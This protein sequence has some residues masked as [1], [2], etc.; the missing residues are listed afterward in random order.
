MTPRGEAV[1]FLIGLLAAAF[2]TTAHADTWPSKSLRAIVAFPAGG[3]VDFVARTV[4]QRLGEILQ[5]PIIVEN[6]TGAS[7][8]I[9]ADAVA[10]A[11]P[12]GYTFLIASPAEVLVGPISGQK[13]PYDP[14]K[15][16]VA[17]T[18]VGETP[19]VI[20]AHPGVA[21]KTIA[22]LIAL[23]KKSPGT[24]SYGTPGAGSSMHF[25]GE[26]LNAIAGIDIQHIPYRGAAPAVTD[27]LGGQVPLGIVGMPPTVPHAKSG[28]LRV[29]AVTSDKRSSAMPEVPTVA[30]T[31]GFAGYRFTN[32]MG[33]Y[34]PAK[35][36]PAIVERIAAEIHNIVREPDIR[37]KLL[38]GGVEPIG[39]TPDEFRAF[40]DS[41][42]RTYA[43]VA[44]D[45]GIRGDD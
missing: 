15:D 23:A 14:Q 16:L 30:E 10:K 27:L 29:L 2:V 22:D 25:A 11:E 32:W 36:P 42:R 24:F 41:E 8:A 45:R 21:A 1:K 6:R 40:L 26:S 35:T 39:N 37:A 7:G 43:K 9:G 12:D 19:L 20:A 44:K 34:L 13:T 33:L 18:L 3:G 17:V 31:P 28:K 4:C 5:Q 38:S